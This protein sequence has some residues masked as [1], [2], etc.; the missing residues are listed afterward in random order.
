M[1]TPKTIKEY[2][3]GRGIS[4]QAVTQLKK[5]NIIELPLYIQWGGELIEVKRQKFVEPKIDL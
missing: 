3:S 1:N 2:A 5:I 4:V